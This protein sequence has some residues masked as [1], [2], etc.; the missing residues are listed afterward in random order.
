MKF[1]CVLNPAL[2]GFYKSIVEAGH[3]WIWWDE[4]KKPA[5]DLFDEE[6]PDVLLVDKCTIPILK[7]IEEFRPTV[8]RYDTAIC[9]Y[10]KVSKEDKFGKD[11]GFPILVDTYA[12]QPTEIDQYLACELACIG[13]VDKTMKR[14]CNP[15]GLYHIKIFGTD[16]GGG[17]GLT[18]YLGQI[19]HEEECRVYAS[20]LFTYVS[21]IEQ[22]LKVWACG[23]YP[24]LNCTTFEEIVDLI[25]NFGNNIELR[26]N[27][28]Q[29]QI[30][31]IQSLS[32]VYNTP[33]L[34]EA[35][36]EYTNK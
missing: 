34:L 1:A 16:N 31:R 24:I 3:E 12:Y 13:Q 22:E 17:Y 9:T 35:I 14:L 36:N 18:Q 11:L 29:S 5:F 10:W 30:K 8:I 6:H 33:K 32:F 26:G 21:S 28:I 19:T 25:H 27:E 4:S 15:V 7:C 20:A 23:G 2:A